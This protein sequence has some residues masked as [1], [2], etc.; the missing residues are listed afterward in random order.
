MVIGV[1]MG[2]VFTLA[3][4]PEKIVLWGITVIGLSIQAVNVAATLKVFRAVYHIK[5]PRLIWLA[6]LLIS[7]PLAINVLYYANSKTEEIR[8]KEKERRRAA[9]TD[10]PLVYVRPDDAQKEARMLVALPVQTARTPALESTLLESTRSALENSA[11]SDG[12]DEKAD[13]HGQANA[14][15]ESKAVE[16]TKEKKL[17]GKTTFTVA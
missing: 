2:F 17:R 15:P 8:V 11:A 13:R 3:L 1:I 16:E 6:K 7:T 9:E 4:E 5:I 14:A 10:F 12:R